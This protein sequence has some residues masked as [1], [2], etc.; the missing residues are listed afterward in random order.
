MK[1]TK[2]TYKSFDSLIRLLSGIRFQ[3]NKKYWCL[4]GSVIKKNIKRTTEKKIDNNLVISRISNLLPLPDNIQLGIKE[5]ELIKAEADRTSDGVYDLLGSGNVTL[6]PIDWHTDFKSGFRWIPGK[7]YKHYIQE[8]IE[9]G[10]DVKIPR[11]LSRCHHL[12]KS[13]LSYR[14]FKNEKYSRY[15]VDQIIDWI[16]EN[17]LMFSI[18][19]GCTM[20]VS[21][22]AINWIWTLGLIS[23]AK[24]LDQKSIN[25]IK[26][27]LYEHGWFI[28]RNPEKG[29]INSHNHYL[30]DLAGLIH[31]GLLFE[32]SEEPKQWLENGKRELFREI[33]MQILPSGM[34][35]ERSTNYNRLALELILI[36]LM[37]LKRNNHEI[38]IDIW[39]R[40]E[41]MFVFLMY[42]LKPDGTTP[43][44][45]DQDDGRLLP[46]GNEKNID[47][48]YLLSL[49]AILFK[50]NDFKQFGD[51]FNVYCSLLGENKAPEI[52][53]Q[54]PPSI[55]QLSSRAFPDVGLYI[56][57]KDNNYLIF[58]ST[59]KGQ[60]PELQAGTHTHSDLLSFEL[61]AEGKTFL[62]DPGSY[63]YTADAEQRM[64]F[65]STKMHN[66]VTVDGQSQ[67][68]I[69]KENLWDFER[70]AIPEILFWE[71]TEKQDRL[72]GRHNGYSRLEQPVFHQRR[73][74][75]DKENICW[76]IKDELTGEGNHLF[77]WFFHFDENLE[78]QIENKSS[79]ITRSPGS[80]IRLEFQSK[81]E[82]S[83]D[84]F[85][86]YI[87]KAY[88]KKCA[89]NVL[90]VSII[91]RCPL[92]V[93]IK[94]CTIK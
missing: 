30:A 69:R 44:I 24:S 5:A 35:Y 65:R 82:L 28:Y 8:G 48:R 37:L 56:M 23:G 85:H 27:S 74:D 33:R 79:V 15:C 21:I 43:I 91:K 4:F 58:N 86:D 54:L 14:I 71:S 18:N 80:N 55:K 73:L 12:I 9:T 16:D 87:S 40:L 1:K 70:N 53:N 62:V 6:D 26:V 20:D 76:Q 50:R 59:G 3:I 88:G 90:K 29:C 32:S 46:F 93:N 22:R 13:G 75:F 63:L 72:I 17:P 19:W 68:V 83:F 36:P 89:A 61:V 2:K 10:S 64:L 11:E 92:E 67:N 41:K 52:Y 39:Y 31:L 84:V 42:C 60:Y 45:G 7:F 66:T 49:G 47:Y 81:S 57:R 38:P 94:I 77:E 78:V 25:K 51:G 34:S